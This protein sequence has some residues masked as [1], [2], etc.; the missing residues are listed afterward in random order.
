MARES[1]P[2]SGS[3][4]PGNQ[5]LRLIF[6]TRPA[7]EEPEIEVA[8]NSYRGPGFKLVTAWFCNVAASSRL[9]RYHCE[10][11]NEVQH[12]G[13]HQYDNAVRLG[14]E[15]YDLFLDSAAEE[16]CTNAGLWGNR[17]VLVAQTYLGNLSLFSLCT[18]SGH[19]SILS[20]VLTS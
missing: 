7:T 9:D 6:L 17:N 12:V 3:I 2:V 18:V 14:E 8:S 19:E 11:H 10:I 15:D 13:L 20:K 4:I 16:L 1:E 5:R